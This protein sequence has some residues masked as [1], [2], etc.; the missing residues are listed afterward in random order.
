METDGRSGRRLLE[1]DARADRVAGEPILPAKPLVLVVDDDPLN[2]TVMSAMLQRLGYR[3]ALATNGREAVE[4]VTRDS[5]AAVLMDCLM[6]EMDGYEA[7]AAI[8]QLEREGRPLGTQRHVP[9]IAVTAVAIKGARER[10]IAAGMDDYLSKPVMLQS[11]NSLLNRW[12]ATTDAEVRW[13]PAQASTPAE[14]EEA[15]I[16]PEALESLR[17]HDPDGGNVM[18]A[19]MIGDFAAE[20]GARLQSLQA[21]RAAG[22]LQTLL[23]DLHFV[24]GCA[25]IVGATRVERLARSLEVDGAVEALG[26]TA[27]AVALAARLDEE[28]RRAQASLAAIVAA[29]N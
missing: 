17:A 3:F 13:S 18:I 23:Q 10:C 11:I 4:A 26:G 6:P 8:R 16:D 21:T 19:H 25:S 5:Y 1:T 7:T 14:P 29:P 2:R 28:V 27:G 15:T 12:T 9:I 20:V 24:A 22:D